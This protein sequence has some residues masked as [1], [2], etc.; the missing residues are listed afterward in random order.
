MEASLPSIYSYGKVGNMSPEAKTKESENV[1]QV[2]RAILLTCDGRVCIGKRAPGEYEAGKW[3]LVGGKAE[4]K[5][6]SKEALREISEETGVAGDE[7]TDEVEPRFVFFV[8]RIKDGVVWR[9]NYY[10]FEA[11][12]LCIPLIL[13]S[14]SRREFSELAFVL[15]EDLRGLR[16]AFGD[17]K[18]VRDFFKYVGN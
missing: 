4:G 6:L 11:D 1:R 12:D 3:C 10:I 14:F 15:E 5:V 8:D 7:L 17:R 9:N 18:V 2:V 13:E 16:F